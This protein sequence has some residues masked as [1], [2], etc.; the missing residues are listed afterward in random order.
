MLDPSQGA[1][2]VS[3]MEPRIERILAQVPGLRVA[4]V[5]VTPL[6]GGITNRN[7]RVEAE[8][9]AFAL[10]IG[11]E[12]SSLLGID[13]RREHACASIAARIGI[14]P[15]VVQFLDAEDA[16]ITRFIAGK[17]VAPETAVRPDLLPR[18]VDSIRR[19]H[20]GPAFPGSFSPFET[21]RSYHA[22]ARERGVPF[23]E[24]LARALAV[25]DRIERAVGPVEDP[26][27]CHNDLLAGNFIDDGGTVWIIDWE[28]AAMGDPFF[29]LGNFAANQR[30]DAAGR[31]TLL[32]LYS[33]EARP[34]DLARLELQRLASDLR[35]SLWGFLQM[36]ISEIEFDFGAYAR[37]HLERFLDGAAAPD[38]PAW[39]DEVKRQCAKKPGR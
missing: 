30:L 36:G 7:Y 3:P 21:V 24:T 9:R 13:R 2:R 39:I 27:P 20:R 28:Y 35:E 37:M 10:R 12:A 5:S 1:M 4:G 33:G 15:E 8:G 17:T 14:G 34:G 23:P 26:A 19:C 29:D 22:L 38:F 25:M 11:G 16:L 18:I 31:E 6:E 32:R